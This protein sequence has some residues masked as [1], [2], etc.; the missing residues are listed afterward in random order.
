M[1]KQLQPGDLV[2]MHSGRLLGCVTKILSPYQARVHW[3]DPATQKGQYTSKE[4]IMG[5]IKVG[6]KDLQ[7]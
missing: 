6:R 4:P 1:A 7:P 3:S 2:R 5:L